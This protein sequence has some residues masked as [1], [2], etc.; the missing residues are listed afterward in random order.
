M[1]K[2]ESLEFKG[3]AILLMLLLHLFNTHERV[4]DAPR[5]STFGIINPS[6]LHFREW[7]HSVYPFTFY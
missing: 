7:V 1:T 3:I 2:Q 6:Y 5:S 4:A